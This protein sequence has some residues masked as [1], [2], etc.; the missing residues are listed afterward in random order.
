MHIYMIQIG[1]MYVKHYEVSYDSSYKNITAINFM[2][3]T[4]SI[5]DA[6]VFE[7]KDDAHDI[8]KFLNGM[9]LGFT[10]DKE[11]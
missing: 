11:A 6:K 4:E 10:L 3:L 9:V 2:H 8:A 1:K 7:S 5:E